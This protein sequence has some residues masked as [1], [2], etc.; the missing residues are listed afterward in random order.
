M[1]YHQRRLTK[2]MCLCGT[3][4]VDAKLSKRVHHI[5]LNRCVLPGPLCFNHWFTLPRC[6]CRM[7]WPHL[8]MLRHVSYM[9][10]RC[11]QFTFALPSHIHIEQYMHGHVPTHNV[12]WPAMLQC[13]DNGIQQ[14]P[15]SLCGRGIGGRLHEFHLCPC[16]QC[17]WAIGRALPMNVF[18]HSM[19]LVCTDCAKRK[20]I[21][22][23][24][25]FRQ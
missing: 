5:D 22:D 13:S 21:G 11:P 8:A 12:F 18:L 23:G 24:E 4:F 25:P 10:A 17:I 9:I 7:W 2:S 20:L 19:S 16:N 3:P 15:D 6:V 14:M 1:C